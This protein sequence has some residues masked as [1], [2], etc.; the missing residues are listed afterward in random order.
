M[1]GGER[2]WDLEGEEE[3]NSLLHCVEIS[4]SVKVILHRNEIKLEL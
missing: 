2:R 1:E 3:R 4:F